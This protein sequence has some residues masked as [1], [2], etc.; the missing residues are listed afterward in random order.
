MTR[1]YEEYQGTPL[2]R[3]VASIVAELEANRDI[4]VD[5]GTDYVVGYVCRELAAKSVLTPTALTRDR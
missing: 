3:A 1:P 4:K 5:T 2:W